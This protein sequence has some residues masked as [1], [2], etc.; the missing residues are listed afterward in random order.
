[1]FGSKKNDAAKGTTESRVAAIRALGATNP[2]N[3][4]KKNQEE[5]NFNKL[6]QYLTDEDPE[7]RL[8]A[9]ETLGTTSK[10]IAITYILRYLET[11][12]DERVYKAMKEAVSSIRANIR[13]HK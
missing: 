10:E 4:K 13:E 12:Q 3:K 11:E 7:C 5:E 1:M 2:N 6:L 9:A 8:A